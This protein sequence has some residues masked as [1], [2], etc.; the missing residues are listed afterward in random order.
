M[1]AIVDCRHCKNVKCGCFFFILFFF[2]GAVSRWYPCIWCKC[3]VGLAETMFGKSCGAWYYIASRCCSRTKRSHAYF[4]GF[5]RQDHGSGGG[6][7]SFA[8]FFGCSCGGCDVAASCYFRCSAAIVAQ[9]S[10]HGFCWFIGFTRL[11][12]LHWHGAFAAA[13]GRG[14]VVLCFAECIGRKTTS[15][16]SFGGVHHRR[17]HVG[18][19]EPFVGCPHTYSCLWMGQFWW[20]WGS[21]QCGGGEWLSKLLYGLR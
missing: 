21:W 13:S 5:G 6:I 4:G 14:I 7:A 19:G 15:M 1:P 3:L 2:A 20:L 8:C 10:C 17:G 12:R 16:V 9:Q 11:L 18:S